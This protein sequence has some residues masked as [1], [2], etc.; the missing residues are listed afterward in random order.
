[1]VGILS[2]NSLW[3]KFYDKIR[4]PGQKYSFSHLNDAA[5]MSESSIVWKGEDIYIVDLTKGLQWLQYL[6]R[7]ASYS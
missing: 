4:K 6:G 5:L 7:S 1:M 3:T 2:K